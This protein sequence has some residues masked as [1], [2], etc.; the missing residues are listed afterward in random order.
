MVT[1]STH[2][3]MKLLLG[4]FVLV[5][6]AGGA[7]LYVRH[8]DKKSA[9][10]AV[11]HGSNATVKAT[12]S[13]PTQH[14]QSAENNTGQGGIIDQKGQTGSS[15]PPS[16]EWAASASGNIVLQQPVANSVVKSGDTLSGTAKV[17]SIRFIL[18]DDSVGLIADGSLSVVNGKFSGKLEF[19]PHSKKGSLEVYY[20]NPKNG[21]EEDIV[22]IN[23]NYNL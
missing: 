5:L 10:L 7:I 8:H 22:H 23:V 9:N 14:K 6:V 18:K 3:G 21:A 2:N 20:P 17:G 11:G 13:T 16:S 12:P 4:L 15:L 1:R 19:T